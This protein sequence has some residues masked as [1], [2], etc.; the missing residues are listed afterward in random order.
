[1]L[2]YSEFY[3]VL[4]YRWRHD[5]QH[6]DIQHNGNQHN[7]TQ[8]NNKKYDIQHN[9]YAV[10]LSLIMLDFAT[11]SV[12]MQSV[13]ML[14]VGAPF[15]LVRKVSDLFELLLRQVLDVGL[16]AAA[17]GD[18]LDPLLGL[19]LLVTM[20]ENCFLSLLMLRTNTQA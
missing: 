3:N 8:H 13:I 17:L 15:R 18:G 5:T 16:D 4:Y 2:L 11:L 7:D 9:G 14:S 20:L 6:H 12:V 19:S 10:M 1:V